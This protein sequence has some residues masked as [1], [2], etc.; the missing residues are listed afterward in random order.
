VKVCYTEKLIELLQADSI[1]C[2]ESNKATVSAVYAALNPA[3]KF[4]IRSGR[5]ERLIS[6]DR[7]RKRKRK[8]ET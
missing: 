4:V 5:E 1:F 8:N 7:K 6:K 2:C 3:Q